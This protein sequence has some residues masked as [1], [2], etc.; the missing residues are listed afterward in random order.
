[1]LSSGELANRRRN[2]QIDAEKD[3]NQFYGSPSTPKCWECGGDHLDNDCPLLN[4]SAQELGPEPPARRTIEDIRRENKANAIALCLAKRGETAADAEMML[5]SDEWWRMAAMLAQ[6]N[7]PRRQ[8]RLI[9][10][11]KM[12]EL[13]SLKGRP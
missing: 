8:T 13:E 10:I 12:R 5:D 6:Q 7:Y 9:A 1:M 4:K 3:A 11:A 2:D